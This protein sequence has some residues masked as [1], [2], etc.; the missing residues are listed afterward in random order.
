MAPIKLR[1]GEVTLYARGD[2]AN[3]YAG[4]SPTG[5]GKYHPDGPEIDHPLTFSLDHS[6]GAVH[7]FNRHLI[8][9]TLVNAA[10]KPVPTPHNAGRVS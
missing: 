4:L 3:W 2:S 8:S 1:D 10:A 7:T 9:P 5:T 6:M